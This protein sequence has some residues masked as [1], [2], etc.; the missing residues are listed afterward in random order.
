[1]R[2][3]LVAKLVGQVDHI[4]EMAHDVGMLEKR[5]VRDAAAAAVGD[6]VG[7]AVVAA[8]AGAGGGA[9]RPVVA[10]SLAVAA[11]AASAVE[12]PLLR[13]SRDARPR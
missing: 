3:K 9:A 5:G 12:G 13:A 7:D 2:T 1:M 10:A 8:E 6:A 11:R 4:G